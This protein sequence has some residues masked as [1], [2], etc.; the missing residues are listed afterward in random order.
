[1]HCWDREPSSLFHTRK[2]LIIPGIEPTHTMVTRTCDLPSKLVSYEV[3]R[4]GY[5]PASIFPAWI[6]ERLWLWTWSLGNGQLVIYTPYLL[7]GDC[8]HSWLPPLSSYTRRRSLLLSLNAGLV[9]V[10]PL[11]GL[12][13]GFCLEIH[14][15]CLLIVVRIWPVLVVVA[16]DHPGVRS[17]CFNLICSG[18][19]FSSLCYATSGWRMVISQCVV[20]VH[21]P[22]MMPLSLPPTALTSLP[23]TSAEIE[24]PDDRTAER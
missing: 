19:F 22:N 12:Y 20:P 1:M 17:L 18:Q 11:P 7:I 16:R 23:T 10:V 4:M 5:I 13:L 2:G 8:R 3:L 9:V 14:P 24:P 15:S 21:L 6:C